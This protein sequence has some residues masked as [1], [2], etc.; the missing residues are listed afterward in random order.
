MKL[1]YTKQ[2]TSPI[3]ILAVLIFWWALSSSGL[4]SQTLIAT[5][6][7]VLGVVLKAFSSEAPISDKFQVHALATIKRAVIGWSVAG[8]FGVVFGIM[9]GSAYKIFTSSEALSEFVRAIPPVLAFP[10]FLVAFNYGESA[11]I[12]TIVFGCFP[13]MLLTVAKGVL[14]VSRSR[15]DVIKI[16]NVKKT[17]SSLIKA[18]EIL[19][20]VFLGA[21]LT[22]TIAMTIAVVTEMIFTP[23]NGLSLGALAR[24]SEIDFNT[25]MFYTS[26]IT[27]GIFGY[28]ANYILRKLEEYIDPKNTEVNVLE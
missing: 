28:F 23:R 5:P 6:M 10:L 9:I 15:L 26:V 7:E 16:F 21:R 1:N 17:T 25:P 2:L 3:M 12:W 18:M 20:S 8:T 4:I 27:I 22:L 14:N 11:Y 19:P 24:D 13:V